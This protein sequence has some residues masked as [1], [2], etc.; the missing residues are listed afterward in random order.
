MYAT[1][2]RHAVRPT[3]GLQRLKSIARDC[4]LSARGL[5]SRPSNTP[6]LR[7]LYCHYVFDDQRREFEAVVRYVQSIGRFIGIDEVLDILE[8]RRLDRKSVV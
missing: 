3:R 6:S 8:G 5:V 2:F 4:A 7:V 1:S